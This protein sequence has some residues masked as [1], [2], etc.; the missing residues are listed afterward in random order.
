MADA[1]HTPG[2][3][4]AHSSIYE[5]MC[6]EVRC[7]EPGRERGIAQVWKHS[8]GFYD[9]QLYAAAPDLLEHAIE[10]EAG[11]REA[12]RIMD[13]M[14]R[15]GDARELARHGNNLRAPIAKAKGAV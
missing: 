7:I 5:G 15:G 3:L 10:A 2:P 12:V 6:A 13:L 11:I 1:K 14:G 8:N 4:E 9:A